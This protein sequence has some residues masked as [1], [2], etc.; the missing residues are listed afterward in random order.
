[1]LACPPVDVPFI[2]PSLSGPLIPVSFPRLD[3]YKGSMGLRFFLERDKNSYY[4]LQDAY[5]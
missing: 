3:T 2:I 5:L 1:M 4:L